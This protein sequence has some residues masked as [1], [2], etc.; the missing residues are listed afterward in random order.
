MPGILEWA[1]PML[2]MGIDESCGLPL[3]VVARGS[4]I[5]MRLIPAGVLD[6]PV[7]PDDDSDA[8]YTGGVRR[9]HVAKP[10]YLGKFE[11]TFGEWRVVHP[12][13]TI[14]HF[15]G[16]D[17]VPTQ[18]RHAMSCVSW[19]DVQYYLIATGLR[20][21]TAIEWEFACRAGTTTD[22]YGPLEDVAWFAEDWQT[23]GGSLPLVGLKRPNAFGLHD[24]LGGVAEWCADVATPDATGARWYDATWEYEPGTMSPPG[25]VPLRLFWGGSYTSQEWECAASYVRSTLP[26]ARDPTIGF[27]VA[28]N[29]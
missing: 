13:F 17:E 26:H 28:R 11:V 9:L 29:P 27:R 18:P 3:E 21:P 24:M 12:G 23:S 2:G 7:P 4:G 8:G 19:W 15:Y 10:F 25:N 20:L 16:A 22:T 14:T 5:V 6:I 1:T